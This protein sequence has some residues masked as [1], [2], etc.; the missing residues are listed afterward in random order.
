MRCAGRRG[1]RPAL[2]VAVS[3]AA[4]LLAVSGQEPEPWS[5]L[6]V[7]S[8]T[9]VPGAT[10]TAE[11]GERR[12]VTTTDVDGACR[13]P[14]GPGQW[15]ARIE[16]YGFVPRMSDVTIG[17]ATTPLIW[18]MTLSPDALDTAVSVV[19]SD[20]SPLTVPLPAAAPAGETSTTDAGEGLV[21]TGSTYNAAASPFAQP[22]AFGNH[23]PGRRSHYS[24][25]LA[26][27][28]GHSAWDAR[29]FSFAGQAPATHAY[30]DV[31][32]SGS[33]GGPIRI[34][35]VPRQ[36]PLVTVSYE[37]RLNT[38]ADTVAARVPTD[39]ERAG[40]FS[41]SHDASGAPVT[42]VD[43][44]AGAPFAGARIPADRVSPQAA[45]LLAYYPL[46][47]A[48]LDNGVNYQA[49]VADRTVR[50][51]LD[52]RVNT[53]LTT[54]QQ[55]SAS[56]SFQRTDRAST[57]AFAFVDRGETRDVSASVAWSYRFSPTR[58]MRMR[59][60]Y[61]TA[62]AMTQPHFAGRTD[63]SG[64][65]GI[66]GNDR[67]P[68]NWGPPTLA[69]G[70][71]LASLSSP[72]PDAERRRTH[73]V[74]A[75]ASWM[76]GYHHITFGG[77]ARPH[78]VDQSADANPRGTFIFSG[79]ATGH[80]LADFLLGLPQ[81]GQISFGGTR[82]F[83][84]MSASAFVMDDW[85][86][87][88]GLTLNIGVRW[89]YEAPFEE[90]AGQMANL[91]L[92]PGFASAAQ[93]LP[94]D[95]AGPITGR[96]YGQAL[97]ASDVTGVQ[98]RIGVAWRPLAASSL[99]VRGGYGHYRQ[100]NVYLPIATWL[101]RQSPFSTS[102]NAE[103]SA[104]R[105]LTLADGFA[106]APA[107]TSQTLAV[108]PALRAGYAENWNLSVQRDLPA[109]L[110]VAATYLGTR[111]HHLLQQSLPN[112]VPPG[113]S[114]ECSECPVGFIYVT[115]NGTSNRHALQLQV[116]RRLRSGFAGN[117]LYTLAKATD[118]ATAFGGVNPSG[119]SIAQDW[120]DLEAERG[121][122]SFDQRHLVTAE[123]EYTTGVGMAGGGLLTGVRGALVK[124]W[125]FATQVSVGSG[126][127]LTPRVLTP[128]PSTGISGTLRGS[129]VSDVS[130]IPPGFYLDP[131]AY[132]APTVGEWGTA[133][134]NSAR[135]PAPVSMNASIGRSF[136][137]ANGRSL[138]WRV[139]ATN[140][141]NRVSY[142]SVN[143]LVGSPQF[144]RPD[145]AGPMRRIRMTLRWRF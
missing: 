139:D 106:S 23:R 66:A 117:L 9:P 63:V 58:S 43:P 93:V 40:N 136:A 107:A 21:I 134:R 96:R 19:S 94:R 124:G 109:S 120:R 27:I 127:P 110:T 68:A 64:E 78:R 104:S 118:N 125:V 86:V 85:R 137:L 25:N 70:S 22:P 142:T 24:G 143:T 54:R 98:P 115:S 8:G 133:G 4:G 99:I 92:A 42:I 100:T 140:V 122:S 32:V 3:I 126:L 102:F 38:T 75:E 62:R 16:M 95:A 129:V 84:G 47:N 101:S 6:A 59:Y 5:C 82:S 76:R 39:L 108:D 131:A 17:A 51:A 37:R 28:G 13:L 11:Q 145:R 80:D 36:R 60:D 116:R 88:P 34:P 72:A 119:A 65:A 15:S 2:A 33:F 81:A 48:T 26:L 12:L 87:V 69:F 30:A 31:Q 83:A 49:S 114:L 113:A 52:V 90:R 130:R 89:E 10:V 46:P 73:V 135:G 121:P 141:T 61:A 50:D 44:R 79:A 57:S 105:P 128:V 67:T 1:L 14:L 111:G 144:G 35:F 55:L 77:E 45:A 7:F 103:T 112:T 123:A 18:E 56:M 91:D 138:D 71:G 41:G 29:P 74:S 53:T 132:V 97:I 20:R